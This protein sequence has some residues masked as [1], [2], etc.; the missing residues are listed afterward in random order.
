[1]AGAE[2]IVNN[3]ISISPYRLSDKAALLH[4]LDDP[5]VSKN[6]LSIPYPYTEAHADEWLGRVSTLLY[7]KDLPLTYAIRNENKVLIG[8]IG[9]LF[10]DDI[11]PGTAEIGYWLHRDYRGQGI[12]PQVISTFTEV[13]KQHYAIT[14]FQAHIFTFNSASGRALEKAGFTYVGIVPNRYE[15][16]G[17]KLDSL[18][19]VKAL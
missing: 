11:E 2:Y 1:M 4:G 13:C 18:K 9:M 10:P 8:A 15:K 3:K 19:Y 5:E 16:G 14:K 6:T 12:M 17:Q 7:K